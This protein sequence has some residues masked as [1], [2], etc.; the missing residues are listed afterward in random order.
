[1]ITPADELLAALA[2]GVLHWLA[3][4][5][6]VRLPLWALIAIGL[7]VTPLCDLAAQLLSVRRPKR[8]RRRAHARPT[9]PRRTP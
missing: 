1:M 6:L 5:G 4:S 2:C 9:T 3:V 7:V 8:S